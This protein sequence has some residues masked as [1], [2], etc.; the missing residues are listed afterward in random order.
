MITAYTTRFLSIRQASRAPWAERGLQNSEVTCW[1]GFRRERIA[2]RNSKRV[3]GPSSACRWL[4]V[5]SGIANL[6][7]RVAIPKA[8][9]ILGLWGLSLPLATTPHRAPGRRPRQP[10]LEKRPSPASWSCLA[11]LQKRD[12]TSAGNVVQIYFRVQPATHGKDLR[13]NPT[14]A[15]MPGA[16]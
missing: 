1:A 14:V 7:L 15:S 5:Q 10:R 8:R 4:T 9:D 16:C 3:A 12:G 11:S 13:E 2:A 6:R